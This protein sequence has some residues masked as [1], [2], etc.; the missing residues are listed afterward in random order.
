MLGG[1]PQ[2][3]LWAGRG[4]LPDV[5]RERILTPDESLY[6]E[7]L[8]LLREERAIRA[9]ASYFEVLR[10]IAA[11]ATRHNDIAQRARLESA[12]LARMLGR[13][14]ELDYV[15]LRAPLEPRG[16]AGR[17]GA[18]RLSDP[19]L[20]FWFR[21]VLPARSRLERGRAEEVWRAIE[22]DLDTYMGSAFEDVV[23]R[24]VGAYSDGLP[25]IEEIGG[26]WDRRGVPRSTWSPR[27]AGATS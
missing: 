11:G 17:R 8:H 22:A 23:R 5:V 9:P 2:Y 24:W 7:P 26:W 16:P 21:Y 1:T 13:L 15:E 18:S 27:L 6:E 25:R 4:R 20:R 14:I 12:A 10:I 3:Q 19:F